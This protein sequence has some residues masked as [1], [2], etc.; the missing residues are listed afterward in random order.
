MPITD[1]FS[2]RGLPNAVG[3]GRNG[4]NIQHLGA[5]VAFRPANPPVGTV[6]TRE[7]AGSVCSD[8]SDQSERRS[9][10]E[11]PSIWAAVPTVPTRNSNR[12]EVC[13]HCGD[14]VEWRSNSA[15]LGLAF[16]DG[17]VAHLACADAAEIARIQAA[18]R[19]AVA[20]ELAADKAEVMIRGEIE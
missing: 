8:C 13:R 15:L 18:A 19:R 1:L 16:A 20:P 3:T 10:Q 14:A 7:L 6:G 12:D 2:A 11:K 5:I 9:E 17:A 4:R